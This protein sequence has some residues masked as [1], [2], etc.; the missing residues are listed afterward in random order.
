MCNNSIF[1]VYFLLDAPVVVD[2][3][4]SHAMNARGVDLYDISLNW[5]YNCKFISH[6]MGS[7]W[8]FFSKLTQST[9]W[10]YWVEHTVFMLIVSINI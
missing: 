3:G 10:P 6:R 5:W 7:N 8:L 1:F 4:V 9:F 2:V